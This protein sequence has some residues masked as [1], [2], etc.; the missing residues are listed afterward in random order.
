MLRLVARFVGINNRACL[1]RLQK[2]HA[3]MATVTLF[4]SIIELFLLYTSG[5]TVLTNRRVGLHEPLFWMQKGKKANST[6]WNEV[7][8]LFNET[9]LWICFQ[10]TK[11]PTLVHRLQIMSIR[12]IRLTTPS[13]ENHVFNFAHQG[14]H[15]RSHRRFYFIQ[16]GG[17]IAK[18]M[19]SS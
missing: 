12:P 19:S 11:V 2:T 1:V 18:S 16:L 15:K 4:T 7:M 17:F 10:N 6:K 8:N 5:P 3:P 13:G 9:K 14:F